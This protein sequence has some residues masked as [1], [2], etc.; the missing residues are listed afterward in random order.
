MVYG[1]NVSYTGPLYR[2]ATPE[3]PPAGTHAIRVWFDHAED[4][5]SPSPPPGGFELAAEDRQFVPADSRIDGNTVVVSS[6]SLRH[7]AFVRYGWN[8]V[9]THF[10]YNAAGLPASTF[11]SESSPVR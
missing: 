7:P 1:E 4:L 2:R 3:L 11:S 8:S 10:L 5:N 6:K 9:V